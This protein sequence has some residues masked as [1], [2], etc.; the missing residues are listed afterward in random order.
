[1]IGCGLI[2]HLIL[3]VSP[4]LRVKHEKTGIYDKG[5]DTMNAQTENISETTESSPSQRTSSIV[6]ISVVSLIIIAHFAFL[7]V[8]FEPAISTPDALGYYA[9]VKLIAASGNVSYANE[10]DIQFIGPHWH[11]ADGGR[12]YS[13][14]PPGLPV[15]VAPVYR[16]FGPEAA[17]VVNPLL[18]SLALLGLFLVCRMWIGP[19]WGIAAAALL[20]VNPVFNQYALSHDSHTATAFFL[21]WALYFLG[22]WERKPSV[23]WA[24]T[25]GFC[26]GVIPAIRYPEVLFSLAFGLYALMVIYDDRRAW[27]YAAFGA[28]G[29]ILPVGALLLRNQLAFG[30]FWRTGYG[31]VPMGIGFGW[32]YFI[33]Y[34]PTYLTKLQGEGAGLLFGLGVAGIVFM[35][36]DREYR[37]RGLLFAA[38]VLPITLLYMAYFWSPD[39]ATMRFLLPTFPVYI[40]AGMWLV[41]RLSRFGGNA[42]AA[43]AVSIIVLAAAWGLPESVGSLK[44]LETVNGAFV[45]ITAVLEKHAEPGSVVIA[46]RSIQQHLD[47]VGKWRLA[48][49]PG[50]GRGNRMPFRR[51]MGRGGNSLPE[52][53]FGPEGG[54]ESGPGYMSPRSRVDRPMANMG[55][56]NRPLDM[57]FAEYSE[58]IGRW[59]G[60]LAKVYILCTE[61]QL[62]RYDE[63]IP[64]GDTLTVIDEIRFPQSR[65]ERNRRFPMAVGGGGNFRGPGAIM[66][67]GNRALG[68]MRF[69]FLS[70]GETLLLVEWSGE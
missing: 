29:W 67:G 17:L 30:G 64:G 53:S 34:A 36:F 51:F 31:L 48:V 4:Y 14:Y 69:D 6:L 15:I 68:T 24:S 13:T 41:S 43:V 27:R 42:A 54:I 56:R 3:N 61:S 47:Y 18:A 7:L 16:F 45:R 52:P 1:M 58:A 59:T 25:A 9:Q 10:S 21:V 37:K 40:I 70:G 32:H 50:V 8:W 49:D 5:N 28:V 57:S 60:G 62:D 66:P 26:I 2:R 65:A 33:D 38:L 22:K 11:L 46:D 35:F 39:N 20:A 55:L 63:D 23:L 19:W 12:C 44:R